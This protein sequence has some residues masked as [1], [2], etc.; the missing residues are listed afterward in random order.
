VYR[1]AVVVV[2]VVIAEMVEMV[3]KVQ[4]LNFRQQLATLEVVVVVVVVVVL[5]HP[6]AVVGA[7]EKA[8]ALAFLDK[9]PMVQAVLVHHHHQRVLTVAML[10]PVAEVLT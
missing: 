8:A 10:V 9:G 3:A 5:E 6:K 1:I 7:E 4:L 2:R